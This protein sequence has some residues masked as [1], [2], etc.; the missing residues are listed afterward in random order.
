LVSSNNLVSEEIFE[1]GFRIEN[2]PKNMD[3]ITGTDKM[4]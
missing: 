2:L 3:F 4:N 1:N